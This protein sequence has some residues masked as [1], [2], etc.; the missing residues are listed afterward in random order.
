MSLLIKWSLSQT[1]QYYI[2]IEDKRK[3]KQDEATLAYETSIKKYTEIRKLEKELKSLS[4]QVSAFQG[5]LE[6]KEE[7][8][9]GLIRARAKVDIDVKESEDKKNKEE[10]RKVCLVLFEGYNKH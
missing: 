4:S 2:Q 10:A 5:D 1:L 9:Q 8:K 3:S 7:E 6:Q